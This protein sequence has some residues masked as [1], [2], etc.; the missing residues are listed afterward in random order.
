MQLKKE[1]TK[2]KTDM[3]S[4]YAITYTQRNTKDHKRLL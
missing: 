4:T 2:I 3:K 1:N